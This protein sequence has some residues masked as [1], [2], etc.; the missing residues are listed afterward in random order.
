MIHRY[1]GGM[2]MA[3]PVIRVEKERELPG[4]NVCGNPIFHNRDLQSPL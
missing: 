1:A 4:K 2:T 3:L